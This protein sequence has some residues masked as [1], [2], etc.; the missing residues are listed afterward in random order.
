GGDD[1]GRARRR[2]RRRH[3]R[4]VRPL[5][6]PRRGGP[7]LSGNPRR[8]R[9]QHQPGAHPRALQQAPRGGRHARR[10]GL[11]L[12]GEQL[13]RPRR[14]PPTI[15]LSG[16]VAARRLAVRPPLLVS[17]VPGEHLARSVRADRSGAP[18]RT[19]EAA[20][21]HARGSRTGLARLFCPRGLS[22]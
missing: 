9:A 4:L 14:Q 13:P 11:P 19:A 21:R 1:A 18:S 22:L 7:R 17:T 3:A 12:P 6:V 8:A 20:P 5:Q 10:P 16:A 15:P 2:P